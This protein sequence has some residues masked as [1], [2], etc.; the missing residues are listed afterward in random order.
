MFTDLTSCDIPK[1]LKGK[2]LIWPIGA[3]EQHGPHLPL[4]VDSDIAVGI[5]NEIGDRLDAFILPTLS[6]AARSLPQSG[7]GLSFPGTVY[8]RGKTLLDYMENTLSAIS[9]LP[10][11]RL[12]IIN[13]HYEN[14]PFIFEAL[15]EMNNRTYFLNKTVLAFSWWNMVK[16]SWIDDNIVNFTGWHA[17]HAG[18]TETSLMLYLRPELVR[19]IRP[20]HQ[21]VPRAGVHISPI[22][23]EKFTTMGVLSSTSNASRELGERLFWH[24]IDEIV[25]LARD[26]S[27]VKD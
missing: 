23:P 7:G 11:K 18:L 14:E 5:A 22:D 16:T 10:I 12:I 2:T 27:I 3:I 1:R 8:V 21:N 4:S 9:K 25:S 17:E 19:N 26:K 6:I 15:D 13:G 20:D 24:I